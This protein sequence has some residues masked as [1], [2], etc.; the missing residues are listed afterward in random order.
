[1]LKILLIEDEILDKDDI[2]NNL[3][4]DY[5]IYVCKNLAEASLF[6]ESKTVNLILLKYKDNDCKEFITYQKEKNSLLI[7]I[8]IDRNLTIEEKKTILSSSIDDFICQP[9][10][11]MELNFRVRKLLKNYN[12]NLEIY[13]IVFDVNEYIIKNDNII[14]KLPVR[15]FQL[16]HLLFS[17]PNRTFLYE[18]ILNYIWWDKPD[19]DINTIRTH[20]NRLRNKIKIF[21]ILKIETSKCIGYKGIINIE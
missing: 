14:I 8:I 9:I 5:D 3:Y 21:P 13:N 12:G 20:I 7:M 2:Y 15:E 17:Y 16:I 10:D 1:M 19:S 6:L 18:E 11:Y 4:L